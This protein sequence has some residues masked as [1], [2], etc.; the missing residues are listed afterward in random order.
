MASS[1]CT[2]SF[3]SSSPHRLTHFLNTKV[4]L[5]FRCLCCCCWPDWGRG[6]TRGRTGCAGRT[7]PPPA[8][9]LHPASIFHPSPPA[10]RLMDTAAG[11]AM[12][13]LLYRQTVYCTMLQ[14]HA[15]PAAP[16][17]R[18]AP[19]PAPGPAPQLFPSSPGLVRPDG[20]CGAQFDGAE[21]DPNSEEGFCDRTM[22]TMQTVFL[23]TT[24]GKCF[25]FS[26][27]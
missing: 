24:Q 26:T 4:N 5:T 11:T 8:V 16:A 25:H 3:N 6:R 13:Y 21:C 27:H 22:Q 12:M 19:D 23:N 18:P 14:V 2:L 15:A 17:P 7:P 10:A 1:I 20:R 9:V